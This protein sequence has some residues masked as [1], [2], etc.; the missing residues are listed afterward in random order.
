MLVKET[1]APGVY[2][3]TFDAPTLPSGVYFYRMTAGKYMKVRR[4]L[5]LK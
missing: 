2:R 3:A 1:K 5:W 4:M